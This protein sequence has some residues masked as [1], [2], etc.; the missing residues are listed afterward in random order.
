MASEN[1]TFETGYTKAFIAPLYLMMYVALFVAFSL[2]AAWTVSILFLLYVWDMNVTLFQQV[3]IASAEFSLNYGGKFLPPDLAYQFGTKLHHF[4]FVQIPVEPLIMHDPNTLKGFDKS[5]RSTLVS[6]L[7]YVQTCSIATKLYGIRVGIWL[8]YLPLWVV[9]GFVGVSDGLT[10]R[11]IR[12][13]CAG[14]ESSGLYHRAK[15]TAAM[16]FGGSLLLFVIVPLQYD[17]MP[18]AVLIAIFVS[19]LLRMQWKY[20]KKYL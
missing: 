10:E 2:L 14:R 3:L 17:P 5:M 15:Y 18:F 4:L 19:L 9:L 11:Y 8:T 1:A 16:L 7:P 20:F 12:R 6:L 13:A